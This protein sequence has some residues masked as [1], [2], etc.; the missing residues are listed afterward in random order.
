MIESIHTQIQQLFKRNLE[1]VA[2]SVD[3]SAR[4]QEALIRTW[5]SL[6]INDPVVPSPVEPPAAIGQQRAQFPSIGAAAV[7]TAGILTHTGRNSDFN[8]SKKTFE[9]FCSNFN[10][11]ANGNAETSWRNSRS[12]LTSSLWRLFGRDRGL[13]IKLLY[14]CS[15]TPDERMLHFDFTDDF[16]EPEI[17]AARQDQPAVTIRVRSLMK[18]LMVDDHELQGLFGSIFSPRTSEPD[19]EDRIR[20]SHESTRSQVIERLNTCIPLDQYL[21]EAASDT[22]ARYRWK[23][24]YKDAGFA[25]QLTAALFD[26]DCLDLRISDADTVDSIAILQHLIVYS[27][28][29]GA[30]CY[31]FTPK[32]QNLEEVGHCFSLWTQNPIADKALCDALDACES[33]ALANLEAEKRNDVAR[34]KRDQSEDSDPEAVLRVVLQNPIILRLG[35]E[36]PPPSFSDHDRRGLGHYLALGERLANIAQHEGKKLFFQFLVSNGVAASRETEYIS[37][38][39]AQENAMIDCRFRVNDGKLTP[40]NPGID[41]LLVGNYSFLQPPSFVIRGNGH[42][43]L[44][45]VARVLCKPTPESITSTIE[46]SYLVR[47]EKN[48]DIRVYFRGCC[49]LWRR[50]AEWIVPRLYGATFKGK[51]IESLREFIPDLDKCRCLADTIWE[52]SAEGLGGATFVICK[53]RRSQNL[54]GRRKGGHTSLTWPLRV[55]PMTNV[56]PFAEERPLLSSYGKDVLQALAIQDGCVLIEG[57]TGIASGRRQIVPKP[58]HI[59]D[60]RRRVAENDEDRRQW[61][62]IN[63]WGTRHLSALSAGI[64]LDGDGLVVTVSS[65]GDIHIFGRTGPDPQL[66]YP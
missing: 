56:L 35:S 23:N 46:D 29:A 9:T 37:R 62:K 43:L 6:Y 30:H 58:E 14:N 50:G 13:G 33:L 66:V 48:S 18:S 59:E 31:V 4:T 63:R 34:R 61:G 7:T 38:I 17:S 19:V 51:L 32:N 53:Q 22:A 10:L 65:D 5:S 11:P 44:Q 1:A 60:F 41:S 40:K 45:W 2:S 3:S 39:T 16:G 8:L 36:E 57:L 20:I 25:R 21:R 64:E 24:R 27:R 12:L 49:V 26:G 54:M 15:N 28:I 55:L 42:G 52:I 47:I